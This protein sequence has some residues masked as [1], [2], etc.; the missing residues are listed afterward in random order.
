MSLNSLIRWLKPREMVFF[1][2][3][4]SAADNVLEAAK[5]FESGVLTDHPG[6]WEDFRRAMKELEHKGDTITHQIIDR[7]DS[8]FVTPIERED[9]LH[10]AHALDDVLDDLDAIADR[11]VLYNVKTMLPEFREL[12]SMNVAGCQQLAHLVRS[13]RNMSNPEEIRRRI[14]EVSELENRTDAVYHSALSAL[15]SNNPDPI[16]LIKWKELFDTL[17]SAVDRIDHAA[18]VVGSTV[19]K[20]A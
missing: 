16:K 7:L 1:D 18:K 20:N 3:L 15:F 17:E 8:T 12:A 14:R 2:L 6:Q 10:L 4:E 9:I 5:Y 13:L 11:L 19:M